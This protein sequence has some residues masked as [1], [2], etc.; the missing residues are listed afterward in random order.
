MLCVPDG[1]SGEA[2]VGEHWKNKSDHFPVMAALEFGT[3]Q[4][5]PRTVRISLKGW[6]T[7]D[8]TSKTRFQ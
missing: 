1:I 3:V 6:A 2:Y 7:A 8:P 5:I 4:R